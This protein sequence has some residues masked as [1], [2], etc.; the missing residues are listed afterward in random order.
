MKLHILHLGDVVCDKG[1]LFTPGCDEGLM[2]R[3]PVPAYLIET[4]TDERVLVDTGMHEVHIEDPDHT[5]RGTPLAKVIRPEMTH[6]HTL[7]HQLGLLGLSVGDV[8]HVVNTHFHF[9]HCGQNH[10]FPSV[11][12]LVQRHH[13]NSA[14]Q[15][16][17]FPSEEVERP[18]LTY[19]LLDGEAEI[20]P[21]VTTIVASGH[22]PHL[23]ALMVTLD[24]GPV[25]LCGDAIPLH[26]VLA[27]DLWTG[28]ASPRD[29]RASAHRLVEL[30]ETT[31]ARMYFGHDAA[32]WQALPK[33]P[34]AIR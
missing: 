9:D 13:H 17:Y 34:A 8:T 15:S 30:A 31:G 32:Q 14:R 1:W 18:E 23:M 16:P 19:T 27:R 2:I 3:V 7:E 11:P 33:A 25:L 26:E 10:L 29:A 28:F 20:F 4:D 21:G 5:F 24:D 22:A 12:I 6:E